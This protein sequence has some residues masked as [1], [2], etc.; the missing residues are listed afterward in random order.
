MIKFLKDHLHHKAG[1]TAEHPNEEYLVA[2]GVAEKVQKSGAK[3]K[4]QAGPAPKKE[5]KKP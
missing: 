3:E 2:V 4:V 5:I 1:T